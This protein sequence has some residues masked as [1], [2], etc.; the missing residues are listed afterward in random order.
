MIGKVMTGKSFGGCV[1]YLLGK[2]KARI[3]DSDGIR[4]ESIKAIINDFNM[5][6]KL[7]PDLGV[8]VGHIALSWS[9][10]D[11]GNLNP[12]SIIETARE[13]LDKMKIRNTQSLSV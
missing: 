3:L 1:R 7:N 5:Q 8:A 6:R 13:Y 11:K 2:E 12:E 4:T 9:A 10:Q